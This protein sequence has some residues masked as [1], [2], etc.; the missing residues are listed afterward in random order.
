V[1]IEIGKYP[2]NLTFMYKPLEHLGKNR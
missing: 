2:S 1:I